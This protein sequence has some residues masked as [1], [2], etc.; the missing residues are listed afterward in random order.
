MP[1]TA[2]W[3]GNAADVA[4]EA[5]VEVTNPRAGDKFRLTINKKYVEVESVLGTVAEIVDAF[6]DAWAD[7]STLAAELQEVEVEAF[8]QSNGKYT[9]RVTSTT[10]GVPFT[11]TTTVTGAPATSLSVQI[12]TT[13]AGTA[14]Q[15]EKQQ[16]TIAGTP[17]G[18]TFTLTFSGQTTAAIAYNASAFT[19][20]DALCDLNNIA[21]TDEVQ[22]L[23][24]TA[25]GGTFKITFEGQQTGNIAFDA[26][27]A[28]I[29]TALEALSNIEVGDVVCAG[30]PLNTTPVTITF[31]ANLGRSNRT[32]VTIDNSLATGGTVVPSTTT[33]GVAS[34]VTV[35][36]SNNDW[37]V[38]FIGT[39]AGVNVPL[40]TASGAS[41]TGGHTIAHA[42]TTQGGAGLNEIWSL[43]FASNGNISFFR[44]VPYGASPQ[45]TNVFTLFGVENGVNEATRY[46]LEQAFNG[47]FGQIYSVVINGDQYEVEAINAMGSQNLTQI[48]LG[49][50]PG[51]VTID[52]VQN[53]SASGSNEV[54]TYTLTTA[55]TGGT[56]TLSFQ[57]QTTAGIAFDAIDLD[58]EAALELLSNINDVTVTRTGS[59][60]VA[61]PYKYTVTFVDPGSQDVAQMTSSGAS[62]TGMGVTAATTQSASGAVNEQQAVTL[63]GGPT[64]GTFTLSWVPPGG[65][66]ET[67]S[68]IAYNATAATVQAALE[69]LATPVPG[70]FAVT[71]AAGGPWTVQFKGTYAGT[72]VNQMTGSG[73]SLTA[74]STATMVLTTITSA[75]GKNF[76][77][78]ADNWD[79]AAV[80]VTGDTVYIQNSDVSILYGLAQSG[81]T[82]A[83]LY[84][85]QSFTGTI[86]L[87]DYS[88]SDY[89]EYRAKELAI[90]AT[91]LT[92]G[93]GDGEGSSLIRINTGTPITTIVVNNTGASDDDTLPAVQWRGTHANNAATVIK[94]QFGV[95]VYGGQLAT[96]SSLELGVNNLDEPTAD[97]T[98]YVGDTV[99]L[100][101]LTQQGGTL[102][103]R[104]TVA[105]NF[106]TTSGVAY[107]YGAAAITG[108]ST[109]AG[110]SVYWL[111][112]GQFTGAVDISTN[113]GLLDFTL[114]PRGR[115]IAG[116]LTMHAGATFR[117][118]HSTVTWTL[119]P[120]F[121][122]CGLR[123]T[124]F[125]PGRGLTLTVAYS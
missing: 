101:T 116:Q 11:M 43:Q 69:G 104:S 17:T 125:D 27:A 98:V 56:Y 3:I 70:D 25:T 85:D 76:W 81:V 80:P 5:W 67:T 6:V 42:T 112:T 88:D 118:P 51:N 29:Q 18:G 90:S 24:S 30:G 77:D 47:T 40:M 95:A 94:G 93:N 14:G 74:A 115:T 33:A 79:T 65:S 72:N 8:T 34:E 100:T 121:H 84:I 19:L 21:G 113:T 32:E 109:I 13:L 64:G 37:I 53:G 73:A 78:N 87:P 75:T 124:Y 59:G 103:C 91:T 114:D 49:T 111:S 50:D 119:P 106:R 12:T 4:Q 54:Q 66:T 105:G 10:A 92:I 9:L 1:V 41:L 96:L 20:R 44:P 35:T 122:K 102:H 97:L 48:T 117:D 28:T 23:T 39:Y 123:D 15:N 61:S 46:V 58:V 108:T 2:R 26:S 38:E 22:T 99:T 57:G 45:E 71:G 89:Y 60:T 31:R 86:G 63:I 16:V 7:P 83:A 120:K 36:K 82:L 68:A 62:L 107:F 52:T 110:G 55:P